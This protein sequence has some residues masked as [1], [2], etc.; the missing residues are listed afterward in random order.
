MVV[1]ACKPSVAGIRSARFISGP[2]AVW[3]FP[4]MLPQDVQVPPP[5][6][7]CDFA[8]VLTAAG[9]LSSATSGRPL[10]VKLACQCMTALP[11]EFSP[12]SAA[13]RSRVPRTRVSASSSY[14]NLAVSSSIA[15]IAFL[16]CEDLRRCSRSQSCAAKVWTAVPPPMTWDIVP[17]NVVIFSRLPTHKTRFPRLP[18]MV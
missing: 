12:I 14:S 13:H 1:V 7:S 4:V 9:K 6:L 16:N 18:I 8:I 11:I 10:L 5:S 3:S 17:S 2:I 15:C